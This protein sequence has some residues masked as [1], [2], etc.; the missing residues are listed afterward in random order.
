MRKWSW[1]VLAA[2]ALSFAGTAFAAG[3]ANKAR[4]P[5][6]A[7]RYECRKQYGKCIRSRYAG[8]QCFSA[9]SQCYSWCRR[10]NPPTTRQNVRAPAPQRR[11]GAVP[12]TRRTQ[13]RTQPRRP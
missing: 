10:N 11:T 5:R 2:T 7:C 1:V 9:R 6:Y 4:S 12:Q 13:T 3:R 8:P